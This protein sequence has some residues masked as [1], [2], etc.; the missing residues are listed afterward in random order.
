MTLLGGTFLFEHDTVIALTGGD[1]L[2]SVEATDGPREVPGCM[3]IAIRAGERLTIGPIVRGVRTYLCIAGGVVVPKV[4]GS[5]S[6]HLGA[7]FGGFAGR[8]LRHDDTLEFAASA[9]GVPVPGLASSAARVTERTLSQRLLRAVNGAHAGAFDAAATREFW[10]RP[11]TVS[12][13]SDRVGVR[14]HGRIASA[15]SGG[16]MP[17]EG[18][19]CGAVQMPPGGEP[20]ILLVD[21]PTTGGYPV[22]ACIASVDLPVLGQLRPGDDVRFERVTPEAA[23]QL[24]RR[25]EGELNAEVPPQ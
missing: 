11:F 3:P 8:A 19:M 2:P 7:G 24:L 6:T 14:L 15:A 17:S 1:V 12:S 25:H 10:S 5:A 23:R 16:V 13:R 22:I 21:H 9:L 18:M 20:I 4:L